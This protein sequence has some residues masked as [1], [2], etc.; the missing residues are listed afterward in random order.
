[1]LILK[2]FIFLILIANIIAWPLSYFFMQRWLNEFTYHTSIQW[3]F[4][5]VAGIGTLVLAL[6][7]IGSHSISAAMTTPVESIRKD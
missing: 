7:S 6:L 2:Q 5:P 1:M 3:I 4:F